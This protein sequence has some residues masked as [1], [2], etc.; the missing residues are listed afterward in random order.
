ME[1]SLLGRKSKVNNIWT[2]MTNCTSLSRVE[3]D[4][5]IILCTKTLGL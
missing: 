1:L 4:L 2:G 3:M 5:A